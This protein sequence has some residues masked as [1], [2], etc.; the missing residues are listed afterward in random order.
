MFL[1]IQPFFHWSTDLTKQQGN[2]FVF[3]FSLL[4]SGDGPMERKGAPGR[5]VPY[6]GLLGALRPDPS[7]IG[8]FRWAVK[9][10]PI[11]AICPSAW[12][13]GG[14]SVHNLERIRKFQEI[15][16]LTKQ[17]F[18][19]YMH[20]ITKK[21]SRKEYKTK[22]TFIIGQIIPTTQYHLPYYGQDI[23]LNNH[24]KVINTHM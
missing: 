7:L 15:S 3:S 13:M 1:P 16:I 12:I 14:F 24:L 6:F 21:F 19:S 9:N 18:L 17:L 23:S 8:V 10:R 5:W 4:K 22:H 11:S 20:S 2:F